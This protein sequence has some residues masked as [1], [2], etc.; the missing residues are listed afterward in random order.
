[1]EARRRRRS[2]TEYVRSG[3][4]LLRGRRRRRRRAARPAGAADRRSSPAATRSPSAS[5][6]PPGRAGL[7][8]PEDLSVVGL[9]RHPARPAVVAAA[10]HRAPAAAG[11]GRGRAAHGAAAGRTGR[12]TPTTS[13]SPPSWSSGSPP[14]ARRTGRAD[15][16][17]PRW[18]RAAAATAVDGVT[19]GAGGIARAPLRRSGAMTRVRRPHTTGSDPRSARTAPAARRRRRSMSPAR[20]LRPRIAPSPNPDSPVGTQR[21]RGPASCRG[22]SE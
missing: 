12:S 2:P 16:S 20:H 3:H 15:R 11:D 13:S 14:R 6:R 9:R 22:G 17:G 8:V 18:C 7:R 5:W 10:D 1:M 21:G 19:R 4:F